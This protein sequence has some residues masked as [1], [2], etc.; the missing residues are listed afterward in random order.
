MEK[1]NVMADFGGVGVIPLLSSI[2]TAIPQF[3]SICLFF[4]WIFGTAS[5]YFAMLNFTGRKR[6]FHALVGMSFAVFIYVFSFSGNECNNNLFE[7]ILGCILFGYDG[8][9]FCIIR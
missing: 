3:F 7:W 6:F 2:V 8:Y 4:V 1:L 5:A 9:F